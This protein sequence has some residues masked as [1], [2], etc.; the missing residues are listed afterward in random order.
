MTKVA[1]L[2]ANSQV[3]AEV[4]LYL[5]RQKE[6]DLVGLIRSEYSSAMLRV[7]GIDYRVV[8]LDRGDELAKILADCDVVVD[9]TFPTTHL[10]KI[11]GAISS[12]LAVVIKAM[13]PGSAFIYMSSIMAFGMPESSDELGQYRLARSSYARIKRRAEEQARALCRMAGLNVFNFRLGQVHGLLQG[14][15][16]D[17]IAKL[18]ECNLQMNGEPQSY[19]NTVFASSISEAILNC[20]KGKV[21]PGTYTIVSS[22]QWTL[23]ELLQYY[24]DRYGVATSAKQKP[25]SNGQKS[26]GASLSHTV[27]T[28]VISWRAL[29][30]LLLVLPVPALFPRLKGAYR[31]RMAGHDASVTNRAPGP[32][33]RHLLGPVPGPT[34]PNIKSAPQD[35]ARAERELEGWLDQVLTA[36]RDGS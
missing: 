25:T 19:A 24:R 7:A 9:F 1:L 33:L 17:F 2:G 26:F 4:A 14:V 27:A 15:T 6:I 36:A 23:A 16:Q 29:M 31:V 28:K 35:V 21:E 12:N 13:K 3:G 34:I 18:S 20:A 32:Q 22:P 11:S 10:A 30:E 5:S 8:D